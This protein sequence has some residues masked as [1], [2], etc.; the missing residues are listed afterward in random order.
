MAPIPGRR[1]TRKAPSVPA[2]FTPEQRAFF[3]QVLALAKRTIYHIDGFFQNAVAAS[4]T[5]VILSL[6][7]GSAVQSWIAP[8]DGWVKDIWLSLDTA[9]TAGTI[10]LAVFKN[11][12]QLGTITAVIDGSISNTYKL[13][14]ADNRALPFN[15]GDKLDLR[16]T[17]SGTF[18]PTTVN[19][20]AGMEVQL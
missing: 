20:R 14:Q 17:T 1:G 2:G 16:I 6:Y 18:A 13:T 11:G 15:A 5:N 10:T 3:E 4:Q 9:R 19:L 8:R 12:S 7:Q